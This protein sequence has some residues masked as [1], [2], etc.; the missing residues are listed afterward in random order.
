M[1]NGKLARDI[2]VAIQQY[3]N[4]KMKNDKKA[5]AKVNKEEKCTLVK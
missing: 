3:I 4:E 5:V 1:L 2:M